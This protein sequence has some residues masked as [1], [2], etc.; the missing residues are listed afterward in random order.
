ML[1]VKNLHANTEEK[2]VWSLGREDPLEEDMAN[3]PSILAW[4]IPWTEKHGRLESIRSQRDKTEAIYNACT[5]QPT[6]QEDSLYSTSSPAFIVYSF[7][8]IYLLYNIVSVLPYINM[9]PPWVYTCSPSWTPLLS[10][11]LYHP[12]GSSQCSSPKLPV[13]CIEP[14]LVIRFLWYCTC[15][16][17]ILP[18]HPLLPLPQSP[19]GCS[20]HLCLFCCLAYRVVITIFLNSIYMC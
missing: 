15:F 20:I 18:N 14:G 5:L 19:K 4:R 2:W 6:V 16:N 9:H 10:P 12:S 13:S 1:V 11:S 17:A 3:H 7:L 8:F